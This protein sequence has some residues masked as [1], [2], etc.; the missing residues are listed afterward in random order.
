MRKWKFTEGQLLVLKVL[1]QEKARIS[2][3]EYYFLRSQGVSMASLPKLEFCG[4]VIKR[5]VGGRP[6]WHI[7]SAG[8]NA[9]TEIQSGKQEI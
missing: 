3:L 8:I 1:F 5:L 9:W 2:G 6:E 4:L 7:T